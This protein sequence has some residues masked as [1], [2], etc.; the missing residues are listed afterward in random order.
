MFTSHLNLPIISIRKGDKSRDTA[1]LTD[2]GVAIFALR[3]LSGYA[4]APTG[5]FDSVE[6]L[7]RQLVA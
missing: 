6:G 4:L 3:L 7:T 2:V 1:Y 5:Q